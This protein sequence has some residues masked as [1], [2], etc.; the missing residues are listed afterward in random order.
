MV[1]IIKKPG[2]CSIAVRKELV[3]SEANSSNTSIL[4]SSFN[5]HRLFPS[6]A[7]SQYHTMI[8][9]SFIGMSPFE[10]SFDNSCSL[11]CQA[12]YRDLMTNYYMVFLFNENLKICWH[13]HLLA[14]TI[15]YKIDTG[16]RAS[17]SES[18]CALVHDYKNVVIWI[19]YFCM[20][21]IFTSVNERN[22]WTHEAN[23]FQKC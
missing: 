23:Y 16:Y 6:Y 21:F 9:I 22:Q 18:F 14:F 15:K 20:V 5:N 12:R 19:T 11:I 2:I 10:F 1:Q 4:V 13:T 3:G 8:W 7:V 17:Y